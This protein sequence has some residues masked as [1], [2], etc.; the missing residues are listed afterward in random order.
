MEKRPITAPPPDSDYEDYDRDYSVHEDHGK[1]KRTSVVFTEKRPQAQTKKEAQ[2]AMRKERKKHPRKLD[3]ACAF[4]QTWIEGL[5]T[6]AGLRIASRIRGESYI[7]NSNNNNI[8]ASARSNARGPGYGGTSSL[9]NNW[10]WGPATS[11]GPGGAATDATG[12]ENCT[13]D[14]EEVEKSSRVAKFGI[15]EIGSVGQR[16]LE[17]DRDSL[18]TGGRFGSMGRQSSGTGG[19]SATGSAENSGAENGNTRNINSH[20][21]GSSANESDHQD[22]HYSRSRGYLQQNTEKGQNNNSSGGLRS[23]NNNASS[24]STKKKNQ[25]DEEGSSVPKMQRR[26]RPGDPAGVTP[27]MAPEE[28]AAAQRE[29]NQNKASS[30]IQIQNDIQNSADNAAKIPRRKISGEEFIKKPQTEGRHSVLLEESLSRRDAATSS[31]SDPHSSAPNVDT[32]AT[33]TTVRSST[34][35]EDFHHEGTHSKIPSESLDS[36]QSGQDPASVNSFNIGTNSNE[37]AAPGNANIDPQNPATNVVLQI[38]RPYNGENSGGEN[39]ASSSYQT[40]AS[41]ANG[42]QSSGLAYFS[43]IYLLKR[44]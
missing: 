21:A 32:R 37:D 22:P 29:M 15:S 2:R 1:T 10:S 18:G 16:T 40:P 11:G 24:S 44:S 30:S 7:N 9:A 33:T 31:S 42:A 17:G 5:V 3:L 4:A 23:T 41:S 28:I 13:T 25:E 19:N 14:V 34:I 38:G 39:N 8:N 12:R 20:S 27:S 36:A 43:M 26:F 35:T 6:S